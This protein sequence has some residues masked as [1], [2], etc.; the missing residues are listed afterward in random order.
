MHKNAFFWPVLNSAHLPVFV[1][2]E[3]KEGIVEKTR[4]DMMHHPRLWNIKKPKG[5]G[6][7]GCCGSKYAQQGC[8]F[9]AILFLCNI[10]A[11]FVFGTFLSFFCHIFALLSFPYCCVFR[12]SCHIFSFLA[13]LLQWG[14]TWKTIKNAIFLESHKTFAHSLW[15]NLLSLN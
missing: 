10:V 8:H 7:S 5:N 9:V 15:S 14:G 13:R 11:I 6:K 1:K 12:K 4:Q 2:E 3:K